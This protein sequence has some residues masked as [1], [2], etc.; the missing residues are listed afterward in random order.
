[1]KEHLHRLGLENEKVMHLVHVLFESF[2]G[3]KSIISALDAVKDIPATISNCDF[4]VLQHLQKELHAIK[5][6]Q[7]EV[8]SVANHVLGDIN[9]DIKDVIREIVASFKHVKLEIEQSWDHQS[10]HLA[11]AATENDCLRKQLEEFKSLAEDLKQQLHDTA[12]KAQCLEE[13]NLAMSSKYNDLRHQAAATVTVAED[14]EGFRQE[15]SH[16]ADIILA[17]SAE[18]G[19]FKVSSQFRPCAISRESAKNISN[20]LEMTLDKYNGRIA[21]LE[22][23]LKTAK[24]EV[25]KKLQD[26]EECLKVK[27]TLTAN[28]SDLSRQLQNHE[29]EAKQRHYENCK[30][31]ENPN[32]TKEELYRAQHLITDLNT[33]VSLERLVVRK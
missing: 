22:K 24:A 5:N 25:N 7:L 19:G 32:Q 11:K 29:E 17:Q 4:F 12:Y 16:I 27:N 20:V 26:L 31:Q 8:Q 14:A 15:L 18:L 28:I 23:E 3:S 9:S 2:G 30:L 13:N 1:M 33:C 10:V 6:Q 21:E